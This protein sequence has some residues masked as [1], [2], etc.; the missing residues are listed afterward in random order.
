MKL[1]K[2]PEGLPLLVQLAQLG[3]GLHQELERARGVDHLL[4]RRLGGLLLAVMLEVLGAGE[5]FGEVPDVL[6]V[7]AVL[8]DELLEPRVTVK[9]D[10][11][12]GIRVLRRGRRG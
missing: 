10:L 9:R 5:P 12:V 3:I 4:A 7:L 1:G 11:R 8:G 2:Q 6:L